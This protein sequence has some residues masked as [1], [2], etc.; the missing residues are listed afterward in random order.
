[1]CAF[2]WRGVLPAVQLYSMKR[3]R[4]GVPQQAFMGVVSKLGHSAASCHATRALQGSGG[5]AG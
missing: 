1:M 3:F 2:L 4:P 5:A